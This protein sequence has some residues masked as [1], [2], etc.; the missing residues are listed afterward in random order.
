MDK[1][2]LWKEIDGELPYMEY[3]P[4]N[5]KTSKAVAIVFPGGGYCTH[6]DYECGDYARMFNEFGMDAFVIYY[7]LNEESIFPNVLKDARRAV[8]IVRKN[9]EKYDIDK[10]KIA[11]IGSSA[12]GHLVSQLCTN[13]DILDGEGKDEI[14]SVDFLPNYQVLCYPVIDLGKFNS[15]TRW[16]Y[17]GKDADDETARKH[18]A[19][20]HVKENTPHAFIWHTFEDDGVKISHSMSYIL[21]LKEK[22]INAEYHLFPFGG[23]GMGKAD[24]DWRKD[25]HVAQW[26]EYLKKWLELYEL[27]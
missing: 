5:N 13:F 16:N 9:A 24:K 19:N 23:H 10:D 17:I 4:A 6:G 21:A 8:R 26:T 25:E 7:R 15:A 11:V 3:F 2:R 22:K 12:G 1:I 27:I 14:D 20:Y 18:S